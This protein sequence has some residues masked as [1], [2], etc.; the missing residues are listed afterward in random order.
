MF[1]RREITPHLP[2]TAIQHENINSDAYYSHVNGV[3]V[4]GKLAI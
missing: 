1:V 3:F 2:S 4:T